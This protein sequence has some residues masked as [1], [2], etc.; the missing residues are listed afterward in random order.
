MVVC[1]V[2]LM[3]LFVTDIDFL[4]WSLKELVEDSLHKK[5]AK[6]PFLLSSKDDKHENVESSFSSTFGL[7]TTPLK[8]SS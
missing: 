1:L 2:Y 7:L 5:G 6:Q 8:V 4:I 3:L